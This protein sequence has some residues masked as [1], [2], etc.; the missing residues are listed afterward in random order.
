MKKIILNI[1]TIYTL[2]ASAET[3]KNPLLSIAESPTLTEVID[4]DHMAFLNMRI[5]GIKKI[6]DQNLSKRKSTSFENLEK[7]NNTKAFISSYN[8]NIDFRFTAFTRFNGSL[9]F[10]AQSFPNPGSFGVGPSQ[11]LSFSYYAVRSFDKKGIQDNIL[12]VAGAQFF[13]PVGTALPIATLGD[14]RAQYDHWSQRWFFVSNSNSRTPTGSGGLLYVAF[15][16][17][18]I[19]ST[20][21]KFTYYTFVVSQIPPADANPNLGLD[22]PQVGIDENAIYIGGNLYDLTNPNAGTFESMFIVIPKESLFNGSPV[23]NS[24]RDLL[25]QYGVFAPSGVNNFD[26]NSPYGYGV[27][28]NAFTGS[29]IILLKVLNPETSNPSLVVEYLP[30][31]PIQIFFLFLGIGAPH[32]GN[33]YGNLSNLELLGYNIGVGNI[34]NNHLYLAFDAAVDNTGNTNTPFADREGILWYEYDLSDQVTTSLVQNGV[35]F[36]PSDEAPLWYFWAGSNVNSRGDF[37]IASCASGV[38]SY[39]NIMIAGR[40]AS[41]PL[42]AMSVPQI[43][44]DSQSPLNMGP[45]TNPTIPGVQRYG[46]QTAI[47]VDPT[48]DLTMWVACEWVKAQDNWASEIIKLLP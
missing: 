2:L 28:G 41:D 8:P 13:A 7:Q 40:R 35:I 37:V 10:Y 31:N 39:A 48:D 20:N 21:T 22:Y 1:C 27:S 24:F 23:I 14:T 11:V 19:L 18:P 5:N 42:G 9:P 32:K 38:D 12:D 36:D 3:N 47:A 26:S 25:S 30:I 15:S 4:F 6:Y 16:D 44:T 46:E 45:G 17:G 34:R 33:L 29:E 43:I